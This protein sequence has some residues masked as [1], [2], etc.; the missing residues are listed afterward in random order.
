M[1]TLLAILVASIIIGGVAGLI[2]VSSKS[3]QNSSAKNKAISLAQEGMEAMQS[4][5]GANWH[6]IYFPP[7]GAGNP[8]TD[9]GESEANTY[10]VYKKDN[11][12]SFSWDITKNSASRDITLDG[13]V[14]SRKV[15]IFNVYREIRNTVE[16]GDEYGDVVF[17]G[18]TE[19]PSS[20]KIKVVVSSS[21]FQDVTVE[22]Y[23]TRWKNNT[24]SQS[25]W[26]GGPGQADFVN[27]SK[28]DSNP[29]GNIEI[30]NPA[31]SIKLKQ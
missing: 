28:Y 15:Y 21:G 11:G 5:A 4:I 1:E 29:D 8:D 24:F 3:G 25:D 18:G 12:G 30:N 26:S 16:R 22:E 17:S 2:F 27:P 10:Y 19:D 9:K 23:L 6:K 7:D 20:Q 31:G 14:Y 13:A